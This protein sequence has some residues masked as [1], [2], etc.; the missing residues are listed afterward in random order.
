MKKNRKTLLAMATFA[1]AAAV[2]L[3][4]AVSTVNSSALASD[5][6]FLWKDHFSQIENDAWLG[7][8]VK[9]YYAVSDG[10][11]Y[12]VATME[13]WVKLDGNATLS[14]ENGQDYGVIFSNLTTEGWGVT[15]NKEYEFRVTAD[16][17]LQFISTPDSYTKTFDSAQLP[18]GEWAHVAFTYSAD[19]GQIRV[20][21]NGE[22]KQTETGITLV[23]SYTRFKYRVG[24][25]DKGIENTD[26][27]KGDIK[28]VTVY[29]SPVSAE[30]IAADMTQTEITASQRTGLDLMA[31]W[32]ITDNKA[33]RV[34]DTSGNNND[35]IYSTQGAQ[36]EAEFSPDIDYSFVMIPDTQGLVVWNQMRFFKTVDWIRNNKEELN[37]AYVMHMGDI[38]DNAKSDEGQA[39]QWSTA[40]TYMSML[41]GVVPYSFILGNHDYDDHYSWIDDRGTTD[42]NTYF[43]YSKY[44]AREDFGGAMEEGKM[45][46]VYYT[47]TVNDVQYLLLAL[48]YAPRSE[49]LQWAN[50]I[51]GS[52]PN[53]RVIINTHSFITTG[54]YYDTSS[55]SA[56][57]GL[58]GNYGEDVWEQVASQHSNVM[59]VF[60][61][62]SGQHDLTMRLDEGDKGNKVF[63]MM[64]DFQ[65][66]YEGSL[67]YPSQAYKYDEAFV[68]VMG[69][70]EDAQKAYIYLVMAEYDTLYNAQNCVV[71][72]FSDDKNTA[73]DYRVSGGGNNASDS[74]NGK[75]GGGCN[76]SLLTGFS[77]VATALALGGAWIAKKV[78]RN[79]D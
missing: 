10:F 30:T 63:S 79:E 11:P 42:F 74:D 27:F 22:L 41:D 17:S 6:E 50:Q 67:T 21:I 44:S 35:L 8:D 56:M 38:I 19:E 46:N 71:Y 16:R 39:A 57:H 78:K 51:I 47:F 3:P 15:R 52:H 55:A 76:S 70:D 4:A 2:A 72:D 29:G 45:D 14:T 66:F 77:G 20:Y 1:I 26:A 9:S 31:N 23:D 18:L 24:N 54:G 58:E 69:I 43:P 40:S 33:W 12:A 13:A 62:H 59:M 28:Q 60:N 73:L 68:A 34:A 25:N 36:I 53:H 37:I 64:I 5:E 49:T 32:S 65:S 61:G 48:E 75:S 7:E